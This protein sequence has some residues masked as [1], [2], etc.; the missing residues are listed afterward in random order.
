MINKKTN[1]SLFIKAGVIVLY[2]ILIAGVFGCNNLGKK[3]GGE[4]D[5]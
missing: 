1:K 5:E 3:Q 2:I 4:E